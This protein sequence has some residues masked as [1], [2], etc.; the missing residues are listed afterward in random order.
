MVAGRYREF[1]VRNDMR[2]PFKLERPTREQR[3]RLRI[4]Q[5][6]FHE[7]AFG[8]EL[9]RVNLDMTEAERIEYLSWMHQTA[10]A[11]GIDPRRQ[12]IHAWMDRLEEKLEREDQ[13]A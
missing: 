5:R 3:R 6:H 12:S 2:P 1:F 4:I 13:I 7:R 11:H 10:R 8:E 9:A